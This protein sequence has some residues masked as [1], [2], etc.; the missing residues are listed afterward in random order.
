MEQMMDHLDRV[1]VELEQ[2]RDELRRHRV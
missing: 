1:N 2:M